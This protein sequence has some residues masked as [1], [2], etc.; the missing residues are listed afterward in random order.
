MTKVLLV[1]GASGFIGRNLVRNLREKSYQVEEI[2]DNYFFEN[3]WRIALTELLDTTK[4]TTV[5]HA[6]ACSNTL[7]QDVQYM[8]MRNYESTKIIANWCIAR[9]SQ[10]IYSSSA[11]NY[12]T[13]GHYP[14]NLY[15][16][17]KYVAEDYVVKSSGIALRYFNVYGPGEENKK[18]MASFPLQAYLKYKLGDSIEIFPG[19]PARDFVYIADVIDANLHAMK[20]FEQLRGNYFEVSTGIATTFEKLLELFDLPFNYTPPEEIPIGYQ[21][22]TRGNNSKWMKDWTPSYNIENGLSEYKSYLENIAVN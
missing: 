7:E 8:M 4:P 18:N 17:S 3:D 16:W 20:N 1:T 9:N 14:S 22:Y 10:L 12:G 2:D 13:T 6:G 5:F 11:A 15:G 21:F 19:S